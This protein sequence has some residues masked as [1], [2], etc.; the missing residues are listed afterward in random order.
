MF[1]LSLEI[2]LQDM[3][4][5]NGIPPRC[6]YFTGYNTHLD[7]IPRIDRCKQR[8]VDRAYP[9]PLFPWMFRY[10]FV[11]VSITRQ[12][13]SLASVETII[14]CRLILCLTTIVPL[15]IFP[16]SHTACLCAAYDRSH[17]TFLMLVSPAITM[18]ESYVEA[19]KE[20]VIQQH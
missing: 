2:L 3:S 20:T 17:I 1:V 18:N 15:E 19:Y 12:L 10:Y 9:F 5:G 4:D 6:L 7:L 8:N 16:T 11:T 14:S 13:P